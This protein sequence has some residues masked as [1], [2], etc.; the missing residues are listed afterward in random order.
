MRRLARWTVNALTALSLLMCVLTIGAWAKV[1]LG[2]DVWVR[3]TGRSMLIHS[4]TGY[5]V[6]AD[7]GSYFDPS[8]KDNEYSGPSG[9]LQHERKGGFFQTT[10]KR[11]AGFELYRI[12]SPH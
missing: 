5:W 9:L 6:M 3:V 4:A 12:G 11:F 8:L 2:E 1:Q 10:A 7:R